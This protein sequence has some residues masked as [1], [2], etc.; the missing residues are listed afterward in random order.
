MAAATLN[1]NIEKGVDFSISMSLQR[2]NGQYVDL[3]DTG[4]C[5]KAEIVEFY[6]LDPITGFTITEILPSGVT[7]SL[8]E[9]GTLVLPYDKSYY[10]VVLNDNGATE[11]LVKGEITSDPNATKNV[12]CP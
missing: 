4:V 12:S 1:L 10:D 3:T 9:A 11:R 8:N 5:V 7:L 6:G 2:E